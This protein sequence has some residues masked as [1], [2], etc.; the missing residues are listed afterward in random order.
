MVNMLTHFH[1]LR[2]WWCLLLLPLTYLLWSVWHSARA[3]NA[4]TRICDA[5]LLPHL[6]HHRSTATSQLPL[7]YLAAA[8]FI[9][10]LSLAGPTWSKLSA[11][12]Y[13]SATGNVVVLDLSSAMSAS[14]IKPNRFTRAKYK[15][16]DLLTLSVDGS[17]GLVVYAGEAY[18][19]APVTSDAKTLSNLANTLDLNMMPVSGANLSLG[20]SLAA[21]LLHQAQAS[22][23]V[24]TVITGS[25]PDTSA[26]NTARQ[27]AQQNIRINVLGVATAQGAPMLSTN[28]N[29]V[30]D[31][32]GE[33]ILSK[34][35]REALQRLAQA[36]KGHYVAFSETD[37]DIKT[38]LGDIRHTQA[39][40]KLLKDA[41]LAQWQ[42]RGQWFLLLL[43]PLALLAFRRGWWEEL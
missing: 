35:D 17:L 25:I 37:Q 5:N 32:Q 40:S 2:P 28:G 21:K 20:L 22:P 19:V 4:W 11:P 15:L 18:S 39:L 30:K 7:L 6:L 9:A 24:I 42:D 43:V 13:S 27:L 41:K 34:L 23:A 3:K 10:T 29:F 31:E 38:L 33:L 14:D 16:L 36:G 1:F 8:W 26:I 12:V